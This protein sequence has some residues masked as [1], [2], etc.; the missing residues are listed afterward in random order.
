MCCSTNFGEIHVLHR[1][2]KGRDF[3]KSTRDGTNNDYSL[4]DGDNVT[5]EV[6]LD[7]EEYLLYFDRPYN[8]DGGRN[9]RFLR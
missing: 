2:T 5:Q 9:E 4:D 6:W 7:G 8:E 1:N 3:S